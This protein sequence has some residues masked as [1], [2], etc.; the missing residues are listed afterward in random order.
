MPIEWR[1][2]LRATSLVVADAGERVKDGAGDG[3]RVSMSWAQDGD[4]PTRR[5]CG[6]VRRAPWLSAP[7]VR[8]LRPVCACDPSPCTSTSFVLATPASW[9]SSTFGV[10]H[11]RRSAFGAA[12]ALRR[13]RQDHAPDQRFGPGGEVGERGWLGGDR[14]RR[15]GRSRPRRVASSAGSRASSPRRVPCGMSSACLVGRMRVPSVGCLVAV[16]RGWRLRRRNTVAASTAGTPSSGDLVG[17]SVTIRA[18]GW[19]APK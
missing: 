10:P 5:R 13:A 15:S 9:A 11:P 6:S 16:L 2:W 12:A 7:V 19:A 1:P 3:L 4:Q 18:W 8:V 17:R 14:A